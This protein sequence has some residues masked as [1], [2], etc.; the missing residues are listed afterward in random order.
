MGWRQAGEAKVETE[1]GSG[2]ARFTLLLPRLWWGLHSLFPPPNPQ[3]SSALPLPC[4]SQPPVSLGATHRSE[5]K[6]PPL[7][8]KLASP[9]KPSD[10]H[11]VSINR[12]SVKF[13]AAG[14]SGAQLLSDL[15]GEDRK[16][17][18]T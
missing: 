14:P 11:E 5:N 1:A 7:Q 6:R 18:V 17:T 13:A 3:P 2:A 12:I 4:Q 15:L 9:V 16:D 10:Y 8:K